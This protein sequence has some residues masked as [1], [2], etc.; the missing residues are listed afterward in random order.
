MREWIIGLICLL[1]GM[2]V[3]LLFR[4]SIVKKNKTY[5][6]KFKAFYWCLIRFVKIK[7]HGLS[8]DT[9]LQDRGVKNV[10][11]YGMKEL[12]ELVLAELKDSSVVVKYA[13]DRDADSIYTD[14]PLYR[15]NDS[16]DKVDMVIVTVLTH[17]TDLLTE[18]REK[19]DWKVVSLNEVFG[20][21]DWEKIE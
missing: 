1:V 9:V 14:I 17:N 12:G 7:Q 13:I 21:F 18:L 11:I 16:F 20:Y 3:A 8:L 5:L 6:A 10:A 19:Y 4:R 15:P 2:T